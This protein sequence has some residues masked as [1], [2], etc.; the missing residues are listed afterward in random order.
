[1]LF[2]YKKFLLLLI[3][4]I[5]FYFTNLR[6]KHIKL[7]YDKLYIKNKKFIAGNNNDKIYQLFLWHIYLKVLLWSQADFVKVAKAHI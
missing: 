6:L 3:I 5:I 1:M 7:L 4:K 2:K